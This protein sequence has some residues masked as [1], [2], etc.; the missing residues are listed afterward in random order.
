MKF[1]KLFVIGLVCSIWNVSFANSC[2]SLIPT[3]MVL[4]FSAN[5]PTSIVFNG[6][7]SSTFGPVNGK[8]PFKYTIK[9]PKDGG[10][11]NFTFTQNKQNVA[12]MTF[13]CNKNGDYEL[14][15]STNVQCADKGPTCT[16]GSPS[17]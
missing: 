12:S 13:T 5:T 2:S 7:L 14:I 3:D 16:I 9:T 8:N 4:Y 1:S 11:V 10:Q 15:Q 6:K 17:V